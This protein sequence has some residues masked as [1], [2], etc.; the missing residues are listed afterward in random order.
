MQA[1]ALDTVET[2]FEATARILQTDGRAGLNTNRVAELAGI[3]VGT[4]YDYFPNKDAIILAMA[5]RETE[6]VRASVAKA[7]T[8]DLRQTNESPV[9]LAIRALIKGYGRRNKARRILMETLIATGHSDEIA[10]P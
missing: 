7:L 9:R 2:I 6:A 5:R 8:E 1:R 3:S 10:K 4:L